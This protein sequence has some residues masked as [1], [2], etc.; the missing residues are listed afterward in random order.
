MDVQR[1]L[2]VGV[3]EDNKDPNRKGRIKVRVQTLF[4]DISVEDKYP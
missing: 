1:K 2:Y 4:N 3:V